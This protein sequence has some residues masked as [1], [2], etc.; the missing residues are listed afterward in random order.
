LASYGRVLFF[1]VVFNPNQCLS[2]GFE[3]PPTI[4]GPA[5]ADALV[6]A[7]QLAMTNLDPTIDM[8]GAKCFADLIALL[9]VAKKDDILSAF[10]TIESG[11][12]FENKETAQYVSI[13]I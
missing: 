12:A 13:K 1:L 3:T 4:A 11:T 5:N 2:I 10:R 6:A 8:D 7:T 9:K